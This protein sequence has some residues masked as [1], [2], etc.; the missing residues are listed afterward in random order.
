MD[1]D[2]DM[3]FDEYFEINICD[4]RVLFSLAD[5]YSRTWF[6]PRCSNGKIHEKPVTLL[7]Q[8]LLKDAHCFVDCGAHLGWFT[9][10][11]SKCMPNGLVYSF[12]M[13]DANCDLLRKNVQLNNCHNVII[14]QTAV[15]DTSGHVSYMR[16]P[17]EAQHY[18][19]IRLFPSLPNAVDEEIIIVQALSLDD[20]FEDKEIMPDVIKLDVEGAEVRVL[21]G[22]EKLMKRYAPKIFVEVHPEKLPNFQASAD[23]V[24]LLLIDNGYEVYHIEQVREQDDYIAY[25]KLDKSSCLC[26][27]AVLFASKDRKS[28]NV[29]GG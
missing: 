17:T 2:T 8:K 13:D 7:L 19:A 15:T 9:C 22:M 28:I 21:R 27:N 20:F 23:E 1:S 26:Q 18:Y 10:L 24:L 14:H 16:K 12:E 5:Q 25:N 29:L 6:F 3:I 4:V 11:A